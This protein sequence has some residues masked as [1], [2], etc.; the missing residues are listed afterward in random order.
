MNNKLIEEAV[1]RTRAAVDEAKTRGEESLLFS[2]LYSG[3]S[4][5]RLSFNEKEELKERLAVE[6]WILQNEYVEGYPDWKL[7]RKVVLRF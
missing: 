3:W 4:D 2:T 6:G 1:K 5:I 7:E